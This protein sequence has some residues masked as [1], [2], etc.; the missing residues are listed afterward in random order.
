[1]PEQKCAIEETPPAVPAHVPPHYLAAAEDGSRPGTYYVNT[2][3]PQN[4][5][6]I[7]DE[8][9]AYH[10]AVPGHHFEYSKSALLEDP[11]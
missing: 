11:R 9:T 3:E 6:R 7:E 5:L 1:M 10:E 4:R 2:K 8:A